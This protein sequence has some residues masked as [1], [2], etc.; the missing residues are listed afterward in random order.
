MFKFGKFAKFAMAGTAGAVATGTVMANNNSF[1]EIKSTHSLVAKY[2]SE[3]LWNLYKDHKT[4]TCGFT[5]EQAIVCATTLD[6]QHC[7]IYA[8]DADSYNDFSGVF[9][10]L[11]LD[12]HNLPAD[13]T[14]TPDMDYTKITERIEDES[15]ILSTRIRVARNVLGYGLSPGITRK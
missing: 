14:H 8:G 5:L 1:P 9:T 4:S 12:Y 3:P 6:N 10:P 13:F 2:V 11:I 7:G 15:P